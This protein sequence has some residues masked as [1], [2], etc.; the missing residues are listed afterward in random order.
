M[1]NKKLLFVFNPT[2]GKGQIKLQ[3]GEVISTFTEHGYD[4]TTRPTQGP[5]DALKT[6]R[7]ETAGYDMIVCCGGDGTLNE[8]V[9][10]L[11]RG[12]VDIP[13]GYIPGGSTN[14]FARSL[15]LS[16][17]PAKAALQCMTGTE[18]SCDIG[19]FNDDCFLY[20]AAF[21]AFTDVSYNT[22]KKLKN[23]FGQGAYIIEAA[24]EL[25]NLPSYRV[26]VESGERMIEDEFIYGM[27]SNSKSVGGMKNIMGTEVDLADGEF[28]VTLIKRP[29][30]PIQLSDILTDL[31][32]PVEKSSPFIYAFKSDHLKITSE[33]DVPW[34]LDGEFGGSIREAE[35]INDCRR[36]RFVI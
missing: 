24:K 2:A 28:E 31:I 36:I 14:D 4:V 35:V 18:F 34:T 32:R 11:S 27:I 16:L 25:F 6:A 15:G 33:E 21:G 9:T 7:D 5:G 12:D 23:L 1:D 17:T 29:Q 26:R 10:G 13:L 22:D 8:T 19:H 20:V 30:N 3:L